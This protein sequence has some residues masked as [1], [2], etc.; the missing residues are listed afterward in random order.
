[1][2]HT[3]KVGTLYYIV[4]ITPT[5]VD[6]YHTMLDG[7]VSSTHAGSAKIV[8]NKL[9]ECEGRTLSPQVWQAIAEQLL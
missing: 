5:E 4:D 8:G 3:I 9:T 2:E 1:M 6:V 7:L